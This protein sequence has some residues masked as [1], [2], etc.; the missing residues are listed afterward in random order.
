MNHS[1][2]ERIML[3]GR[4]QCQTLLDF[5]TATENQIWFW[6]KKQVSK[7]SFE[8]FTDKFIAAYREQG[9]LAKMQDSIL[10]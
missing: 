1:T 7:S 3:E 2:L 5:N 8:N 6:G 10:R 4:R 9:S